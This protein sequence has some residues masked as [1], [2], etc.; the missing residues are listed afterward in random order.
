MRLHGETA[1]LSEAL[2][3]FRAEV[4]KRHG[5]DSDL[6]IMDLNGAVQTVT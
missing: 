1:K 6:G 4:K 3:A 2:P 5:L